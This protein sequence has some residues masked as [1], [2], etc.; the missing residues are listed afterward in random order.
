M[1]DQGDYIERFLN[2]NCEHYEYLH[3]LGDLAKSFKREREVQ[4]RL[5]EQNPDATVEETLE[6]IHGAERSLPTYCMWEMLRLSCPCC[7]LYICKA[8]FCW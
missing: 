3:G 8:E 1:A 6:E 2:Q 7:R 5:L 4:A